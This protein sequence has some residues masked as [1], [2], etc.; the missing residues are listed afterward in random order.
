MVII[1]DND[2]GCITDIYIYISPLLCRFIETTLIYPSNFIRHQLHSVAN[3]RGLP[4]TMEDL[5]ELKSKGV[6]AMAPWPNSN[7]YAVFEFG[8]GGFIW[9]SRPGEDTKSY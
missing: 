8:T 1:H 9:N 5:E 7:L 2:V 3:F 6:G 4:R